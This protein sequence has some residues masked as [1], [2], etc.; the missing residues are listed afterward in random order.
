MLLVEVS[1]ETG[2]FKHLS[3]L[4]FGVCTFG[5]TKSMRFVSFSKCSKFNLDFK[6]AAKNIE[7]VFFFS[8]IV[9]SELVLLNCLY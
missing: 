9:A 6:Y 4:D 2:L 5:I 7:N 1:S 3:D 8:E